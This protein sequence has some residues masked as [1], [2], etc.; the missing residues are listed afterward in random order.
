MADVVPLA[1]TLYD[2]AQDDASIIAKLK[3]ERRSLALGS[4]DG[5]T[6]GDVVNAS[7]NGA[8][9]TMRPGYTVQDRLNVLAMA[10]NAIETKIRPSR[11][12]RILFS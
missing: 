10:I 7:K 5:T 8:S 1:Q 9:Y 3:T 2:L 11:N 12:K 4:I 6:P